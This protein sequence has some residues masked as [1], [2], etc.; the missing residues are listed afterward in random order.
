MSVNH[1]R[2]ATLT[3]VGQTI[4]G[5]F[6]I[7]CWSSVAGC[8]ALMVSVYC[9]WPQ[10]FCFFFEALNSNFDFINFMKDPGL[11]TN[12]IKSEF[13][14]IFAEFKAYY[15][16]VGIA[17]SSISA[18]LFAAVLQTFL[19]RF[20]AKKLFQ[21]EFVRGSRLL[22]PGEFKPAVKSESRRFRSEFKR[23]TGFK[24]NNREFWGVPFVFDAN[25]IAVPQYFLMR[26]L[27]LLGVPG[28]GKSTIIGHALERARKAGEKCFVLDPNGEFY[29]KFGKP[30]DKILS[31][32]DKRSERWEAHREIYNEKRFNFAK[33]AEFLVAEGHGEKIWWAGA[34][35]VL[36]FLFSNTESM[37]ELKRY[38]LNLDKGSLK[39]LEDLARGISGAPGSKQ[40]A[41]VA[42]GALLEL[43]FLFDL[44]YWPKKEGKQ[45]A[46]SVY[47]WAQNDSREWVFIT[48]ADDDKNISAPLLRIWTNLAIFGILARD[49]GA[50]NVPVNVV[51]D[52]M[53]DVGALEMLVSAERRFRKYRGQLYLGLQSLSQFHA[54][55][56]KDVADDMI[57]L[58][59]TK[60]FMRVTNPGEARTIAGHIGQAEMYEARES[61]RIGEKQKDLS[62]S[63]G[64]RR[65]RFVAYPDDIR[66]LPDGHFYLKSLNLNPVKSRIKYKVWKKINGLHKDFHG[67]PAQRTPEKFRKYINSLNTVKDNTPEAGRPGADLLNFAPFS[68]S[69]TGDNLSSEDRI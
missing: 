21:S 22:S 44:N 60:V 57:S 56:Q 41:G 45:E 32:Y 10:F 19:F 50:D 62:V 58:I 38:I 27:M 34:R 35:E 55:Y 17:V 1:G 37:E 63:R 12:L 13:I 43:S 26:S 66:N 67:Y 59:G 25:K 8:V 52:E 54:L 68:E 48:Y 65:E 3:S 9:L 49:E 31:L 24:I 36:K 29:G 39:Y 15:G 46:F 61:H 51:V 69:G 64:D 6:F 4:S 53:G 28:T 18:F 42:A 11:I 47:D 23:D 14:R 2:I 7:F 16:Y 20:K 40:E 5:I 33:Y 30:G